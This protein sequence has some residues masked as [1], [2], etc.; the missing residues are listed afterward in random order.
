MERKEATCILVGL[1]I[2]F[3]LWFMGSWSCLF[4]QDITVTWTPSP[5]QGVVNQEIYKAQ[6]DYTTGVSTPWELVDDTLAP[7]ASTYTA[8]GLDDV[9]DWIF[10][11]TARDAEGDM[12]IMSNVAFEI[13]SIEAGQTRPDKVIELRIVFP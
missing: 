8:V 3:V 7:D 6:M 4:A 9:V 12:S 13:D 1:L 10:Q 5:T 2:V 11:V